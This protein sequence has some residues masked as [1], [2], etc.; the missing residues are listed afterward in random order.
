MMRRRQAAATPT[1][2]IEMQ[3]A[4]IIG[5]CSMPQ[6]KGRTA[7]NGSGRKTVKPANVQPEAMIERST[8]LATSVERA[9][10]LDSAAEDAVRTRAY[11]LFLERGGR[12]GHELD[13]WLRAEHEIH[14]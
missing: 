9:T 13:D 12:T 2:S 10:T 4:H 5:G 3:A 8:Q 6:K 1:A 7:T 11:F 14:S